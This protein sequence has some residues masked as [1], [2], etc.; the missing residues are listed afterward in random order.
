[1]SPAIRWVVG[2]SLVMAGALG[3]GRFAYTPL[4]PEM[5]ATFGWTYAQAGDV[6]SANFLG[7]LLGAILAP[8][9]ARSPYVRAYVALSLMASV[10]TTALGAVVF[11][12]TLWLV[13]RLVAG[14]ASAACLVVLTTHLLQVLARAGADHLGNIHFAGVGM[15]ILL[16]MAGV[17]MTGSVADQWARQGLL[18]AVVMAGAWFMLAEGPWHAQAPQGAAAPASTQAS[19]FDLAR[20]I[21]GYGLFGFG[22]V[23]SATF[24]VAMGERLGESGLNPNLTWVAVDAAT[25]P[26]VY[27]WQ[28]LAN[29]AGLGLALRASYLVLAAGAILAGIATSITALFI[30]A[31]LLGGTFGGVTALGLSAGRA[32][33]LDRVAAIV[34]AM[35]VA[36]S[37]GQLLGP[38][39][40]GRMA[41]TL[42]GF[43]W[44]SVLA[45]ALVLVS[46]LALPRHPLLR[47]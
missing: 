32:L 25:V 36:F 28:W 39:V 29:R 42:G 26:S 18:S 19:R 3:I 1:M 13:L 6:A 8:V 45:G 22:Y 21:L 38:A 9:L 20:V 40:A 17:Y 4:L 31:V 37:I 10:G 5:V 15:G 16:C 24:V 23:V 7:Y 33:A 34:S 41:D 47:R 44:P 35:T 30:A 46:A 11:D 43:L 2:A 27:L 12:H 14:A